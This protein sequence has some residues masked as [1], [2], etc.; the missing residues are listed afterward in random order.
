MNLV[1]D[2]LYRITLIIIL[3][4]L[5]L[6]TGHL[7]ANVKSEFFEKDQCIKCHQADEV[8][9]ED[10]YENDIHLQ[11]GLSCAGCHGGDPQKDD[12]DEA[13]DPASGYIGVPSKRDVPRLCG[14]CHSDI[15][16]MREYQPRI[17][18]DQVEQYYTSIHGQKLKTGDNKVADCTNCHTAHGILPAKDPRST[19]YP[20]NL[21]E[22]CNMCHGDAAYMK[23]YNI[24]TSQYIE[25]SE[26]VHGKKL[27]E[28]RDTGSPACND[29]HG[30]HGAMPP[31]LT[32]VSHV[33]G[34]CHVNNMEYFSS[35]VMGQVFEEQELH[36][37][38]E[39]HGHHDVQKTS[40]DM[41]GVGEKS[42][43]M[44]CHSE[45]DQGYLVADT[46]Y[47]QL[48]S[49]VAMYD[50]ALI[51]ISEVK[52]KGMNDIEIGFLLSEAK[53]NLI[54]SRTLVHTFD[55]EKTGESTTASYNKSNTAISLAEIEIENYHVRRRGFGL[56]TIFITVIV[57]A[58]FFKI[59]DI[60]KKRTADSTEA[61]VA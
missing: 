33:C 35:S 11:S 6:N 16:F 51:R 13:M 60:E 32:S 21:P 47:R 39:C 3:S 53:Q 24:S 38:E 28:E 59:R 14:K 29:C 20:L 27:L 36:A 31:G 22:T 45:G 12:M 58:L 48:N 18:V 4:I 37:C 44:D 46:I 19:V 2:N 17:S 40:D 9:P 15:N 56:A 25:F 1:R 61:P 23:S 30:N 7:F 54:Q 42:V 34:M 10:F 55:P 26:S 52:R 8:L 49:A 41:I 57:I 50:S 43:C 5:T